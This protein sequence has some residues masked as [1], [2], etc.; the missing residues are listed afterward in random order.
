MPAARRITGK[1]QPRL[2][3]RPLRQLRRETSAGFRFIEF[4]DAIGQPLLP[5]QRWLAVHLL[6]LNRDG[7]FRFRIALIMVARQNGK[8]SMARLLSLFRLFVCADRLIL[9]TAQDL[10]MA[11]ES[12]GE[13]VDLIRSSAY[14]AA[15]LAEVRRA[16]GDEL[17][18]ISNDVPVEYDDV[19]G[20]VSLT[21]AAG[22]RYKIC[23]PNRRAGR[24]LS[25]DLL[26]IDELR[27]WRSYAPYSALSKTTMARENGMVLGTSNAG[28]DQSVVLNQLRDAALSD[29][30]ESIGLFEWS[31][32][33]DADIHDPRAWAAANPG[34][35][36]ILSGQALR[37]AANSDRITD[38]RTECLCQHVPQLDGAIDLAAWD[39]CYDPAGSMAPYRRH[40]AAGFDISPDG[41]HCT[42][43]VAARLPDGRVRAEVAGAWKSTEAARRELPGLLGKLRPKAVGWFPAGPAGSF[44]SVLRAAPGSTELNGQ[45][46]AQACME[47]SDVVHARRLLQAGEDVL[48]AQVRGAT[49]VNS[50][51]G[52]KF[53]RRKDEGPHVDAVYALAAAVSAALNAPEPVRARLR[54]LD[55]G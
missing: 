2:F 45:G 10:S 28:D 40:L 12:Q 13:C 46:A 36:Y 34:L 48:T 47:L 38:F 24:G 19:D 18:R 49:R 25:V 1:T 53:S 23:A 37:T 52:W 35:G 17:F 30:D 3:T 11:R 50:A 51:D 4:C 5:W 54:I 33:P 14:L 20:D 7:T 44:A 27:E 21:M 16:N 26:L 8:S 15:D 31:A 39:A 29:G 6:E 9:G 55:A 43:C 32:E 41:E 22:G 42:L